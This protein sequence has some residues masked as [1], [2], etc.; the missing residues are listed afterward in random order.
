MTIPLRQVA[1]LFLTRGDMPHEASWAA[2]LASVQGMIPID[3]VSE[4]S[5]CGKY[6][7]KCQGQEGK[8]AQLVRLNL[9]SPPIKCI[10]V[11]HTLQLCYG[12]MHSYVFLACKQERPGL[13]GQYLY[14]VYV[15]P[16]PKHQP[17][18]PGSLFHGREV[19]DRVQVWP[20]KCMGKLITESPPFLPSRI[21]PLVSSAT[22]KHGYMHMKSMLLVYQCCL[23]TLEMSAV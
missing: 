5:V 16:A 3:R 2:W 19:P 6:R 12:N 11:S 13:M 1:L 10:P 14:T 22:C 15:H 9:V 4:S 17:Y 20:I 23:C 7:S 18:P 8:R 21:C